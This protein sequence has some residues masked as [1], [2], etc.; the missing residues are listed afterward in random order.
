MVWCSGQKWWKLHAL[1]L[2]LK[3]ELLMLPWST[4][5]SWKLPFPKAV[6]PLWLP[7]WQNVKPNNFISVIC[8]CHKLTNLYKISLSGRFQP[9][10]CEWCFHIPIW[11][12]VA[13]SMTNLDDP[14]KLTILH[15]SVV[16]I[17]GRYF[18]NRLVSVTLQ[19]CIQFGQTTL[20]V[21]CSKILCKFHWIPCSMQF[22]WA[23]VLLVLLRQTKLIA[24]PI[25]ATS[26]WQPHPMGT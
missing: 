6:I 26:R 13:H 11:N 19:K 24:E 5:P 10:Q 16:I 20:W 18:Q 1:G 23:C 7:F 4:N 14:Q 12:K 25:L 2:S 22:C 15:R 17:K 3:S 8:Q 9:L 21:R